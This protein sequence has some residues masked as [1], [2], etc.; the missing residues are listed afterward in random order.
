MSP[1]SEELKNTAKALGATFNDVVLAIA[2]GGFREL[3]LRH[4]GRADSPL[5]AIVPVC[6]DVSPDRLDGNAISRADPL[7]AGTRR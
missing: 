7:T 5:L 1:P 4:D 2:S 3:L 6:T